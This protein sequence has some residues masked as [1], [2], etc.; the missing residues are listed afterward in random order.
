M[1]QYPESY[2]EDSDDEDVS[3]DVMFQRKLR[4]MAREKEKRLQL[5]ALFDEVRSM[6]NLGCG[7]RIEKRRV[8]TETIQ[9]ISDLRNENLQLKV[10]TANL[11]REVEC[12][13]RGVSLDVADPQKS[14]AEPVKPAFVEYHDAVDVARVVGVDMTHDSIPSME[15]GPFDVFHERRES[16]SSLAAEAEIRQRDSMSS[17]GE[18]RQR[19]SIN[20]LSGFWEDESHVKLEEMHLSASDDFGG[21]HSRDNSCFLSVMSD[22]SGLM[23]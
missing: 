15:R 10:S 23:I 11:E 4:K 14:T 9:A 3:A 1:H 22:A 20:S 7:V 6:L 12:R 2:S 19:D 8:L 17:L 16:S 21:L 18:H 5:N 13:S